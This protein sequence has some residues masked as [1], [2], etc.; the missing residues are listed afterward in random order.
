MRTKRGDKNTQKGR[1]RKAEQFASA[2]IIVSEFAGNDDD[3]ND[4]VVTLCVHAGIAASDVICIGTLGEYASGQNH[5]ESLQLLRKANPVAA[6]QLDTLLGLKTLAGYSHE[7][8][9]ATDRKRAERAMN[10]LLEASR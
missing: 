7:S 8:A 4:A 6:K 2:A 1:R 3:I 9:T 10:A 5:Q